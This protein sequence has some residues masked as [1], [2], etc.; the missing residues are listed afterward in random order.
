LR[1]KV[2]EFLQNHGKGQCEDIIKVFITSK[3]TSFPLMV[4]PDISRAA[5]SVSRGVHNGDNLSDFLLKLTVGFRGQGEDGW[6][7]Q[8]FIIR[9][10]LE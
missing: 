9:T 6:V 2:P 10:I 8:N 1:L 4:L 3:P 5:S 7:T